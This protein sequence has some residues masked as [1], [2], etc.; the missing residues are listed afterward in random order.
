[1]NEKCSAVLLDEL[2]S[3][4]KD[5][6]SLTTPC[7]VFEKPKEA[8]DLVAYHLSRFQKPHMEVLTEREIVDN[9][10]DKHLMVLKSKFNYNEPW[11]NWWAS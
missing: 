6:R 3:K 7:Q 1:M 4:E 10:F 11:T 8:E 2:S 5:P 9:F